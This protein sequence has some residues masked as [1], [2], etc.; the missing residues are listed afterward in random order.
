M[1]GDQSSSSVPALWGVKS[2][3]KHRTIV[4]LVNNK[5]H[6]CGNNGFSIVLFIVAPW[7][8]NSHVLDIVAEVP[9]SK[10]CEFSWGALGMDEDEWVE[11]ENKDRLG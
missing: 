7:I 2:E 8:R 3:V 11:C 6:L 5:I 10:E 9:F 4:E 1:G